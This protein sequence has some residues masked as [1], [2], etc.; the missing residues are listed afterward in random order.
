MGIFSPLEY[1]LSK[2]F[3]SYRG[4]DEK[5]FSK[6]APFAEFIKPTFE[7]T[8]PECGPS[9]SEMKVHHTGF[10]EDKFPELKWE[11]PSPDV[12]QYILVVEDA[13]VPFPFTPS[14]GI[15]HSISPDVTA[16]TPEDVELV[17]GREKQK[18]LKGPLKC[19]KN[20]LGTHY[21]GPKPLL[22][23]G[24]HRY[25]FQLVALKEPL[26][27]K[28]LSKLPDKAELGKA[29]NGKVMGW[30]LWVGTYEQK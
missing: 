9:G 24:P 27:E 12:K 14:H 23:H 29:I 3:Y 6:T 4:R 2:A 19:G 28:K 18:E 17:K 7:I 21:A 11:K 25:F 15:F 16:I 30:G 22:G 1:G 20:V 13:D 5:L 26:D 8:S 10:G